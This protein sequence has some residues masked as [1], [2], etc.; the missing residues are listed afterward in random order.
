M[1]CQRC[2]ERT[3]HLHTYEDYKGA[4]SSYY[5]CADCSRKAWNCINQEA[6]E[7]RK[8]G[9]GNKKSKPV[10]FGWRRNRLGSWGVAWGE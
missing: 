7:R 6:R 10:N 9:E 3:G 1:K 8:G 2:N 5:H 4:K